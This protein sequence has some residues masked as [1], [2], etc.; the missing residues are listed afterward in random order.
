MFGPTLIPETTTSGR[1][2]S[3][4][5]MPSTTQSAGVPF[6]A[7]VGASSPGIV[8]RT[9]RSG[10]CNVIACPV[11]LRSCSG[12]TTATGTTEA[13]CFLGRGGGNEDHNVTHDGVGLERGDVGV[14][15]SDGCVSEANLH[16]RGGP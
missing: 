2:S 13:F 8:A 11:A 15:D 9:A 1:S 16:D 4:S 5:S 14:D 10:L 6:V 3:R 7:Q 12:A